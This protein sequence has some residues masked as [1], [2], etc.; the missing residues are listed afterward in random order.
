MLKSVE[1]VGTAVKLVPLGKMHEQ[2][3]YEAAK[4][5]EI[6]EHLPV[7]VHSLSDMKRL[8]ESALKAKRE[9]RELPFAVFDV[10]SHA[11]VGSTRFLDISLPNKSVEIGWTWYH[12]SVWRSRVNTE[13]KYLL[14]KYCFEE[15]KLHR[16][17]FK[18]DVR[19][20]RSRKAI[21][22]LGATQEGISRKH[23]VLPDGYVRDSVIFSIID[24]EWPFVKK[25]L[26]SFLHAASQGNKENASN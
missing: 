13:C 21:K 5:K 18:T 17:Q 4:P 8:I 26:E 24:D 11:I 2:G 1:L 16:V 15:L 10:K 6:W 25:R 3:L 14:L 19:N 9:G 23:M 22:R 12:P 7:K 20:N